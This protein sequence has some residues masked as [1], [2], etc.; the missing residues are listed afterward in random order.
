MWLGGTGSAESCCFFVLQIA[1]MTQMA[2]EGEEAVLNDFDWEGEDFTINTL[3]LV[4]QD[5]LLVSTSV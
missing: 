2:E 5:E 3:G 1:T 4:D